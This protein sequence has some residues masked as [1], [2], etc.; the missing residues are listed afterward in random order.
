MELS[1]RNIPGRV[2]SKYKGPEAGKLK[3]QGKKVVGD[4]GI[5]KDANCAGFLYV[6]YARLAH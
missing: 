4:E 3:E 1:G 6:I 2:K 5:K